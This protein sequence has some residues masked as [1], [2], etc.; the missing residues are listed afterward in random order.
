MVTEFFWLLYNNNLL[1]M[2]QD[3]LLIMFQDGLLIMFQDGLLIMF[4]D[5]FLL[6][7][8]DGTCIYLSSS[9]LP[10]YNGVYYK[11]LVNFNNQPVYKRPDCTLYLFYYGND[12]MSYWLVGPSLGRPAGGLLSTGGVPLW[13]VTDKRRLWR[14][15]SNGSGSFLSDNSVSLS[16]ACPCKGRYI[17][18]SFFFLCPVIMIKISLVFK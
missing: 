18:Y 13:K 4:Q 17:L 7:F 14:V 3:G 12:S 15:Y 1:I 8:V 5:G 9:L 16:Y 11:Q 2:F 10:S 6:T